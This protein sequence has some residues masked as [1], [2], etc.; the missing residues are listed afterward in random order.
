MT[1]LTA[2]PKRVP[3]VGDRSSISLRNFTH[4]LAPNHCLLLNF[5]HQECS[6]MFTVTWFHQGKNGSIVGGG[7]ESNPFEAWTLE[8]LHLGQRS[9]LYSNTSAEEPQRKT[10]GRVD[11]RLGLQ[12]LCFQLAWTMKTTCGLGNF[13]CSHILDLEKK[14]ESWKDNFIN[15]G[16]T[17][18]QRERTLFSSIASYCLIVWR[19]KCVSDH[20]LDLRNEG[21]AG[22]SQVPKSE[23]VSTKQGPLT[24]ASSCLH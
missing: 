22:K 13:N 12:A 15:E 11:A 16:I 6:Y 9:T 2:P 3:T 14:K 18:V 8:L 4:T 17:L 5:L 7:W 21:G 24:N 23:D 10:L 20:C 1:A 19:T